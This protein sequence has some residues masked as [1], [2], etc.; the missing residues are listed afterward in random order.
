[1]THKEAEPAI[2][3]LDAKI[4]EQERRL[5]RMR[6]VADSIAS[7]EANIAALRR[8]RA[9][10]LGESP[11]AMSITPA[12]GTVAILGATHSVSTRPGSLGAMA[13][14]II[15]AKGHPM[16]VTEITEAI[17]ATGRDT[18]LPTVVG[19]VA[20]YARFGLLRKTGVSTYGLGDREAQGGPT[21]HDL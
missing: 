12:T 16:H 15:E 6:R 5:Q 3:A 11:R 14:R 10:L 13:V 20:R 19:A 18:T 4:I 7:V 9:L 17:R 1:M 8:S 21:E 2:E